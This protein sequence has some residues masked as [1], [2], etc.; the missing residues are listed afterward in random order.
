MAPKRRRTCSG[1]V[2][3]DR[4]LAVRVKAAEGND[5]DLPARQVSDL[6]IIRQL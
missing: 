5:N 3:R 6:L 2:A 4:G 1:S